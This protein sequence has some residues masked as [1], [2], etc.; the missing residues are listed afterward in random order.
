MGNQ[1][2]SCHSLTVRG[3]M[4]YNPERGTWEGNEAQL[5]DFQPNGPALIRPKGAHALPP[6]GGAGQSQESHGMQWDPQELIWRGN[7]RAVAKFPSTT[8]PALISQLNPSSEPITKNDMVFD[9]EKM[10]WVG[11][12]TVLDIFSDIET[13][14]EKNAFEVGSEFSLSPELKAAFRRRA[15]HHKASLEGWLPRPLERPD[16]HLSAIRSV[17]SVLSSSPFRCPSFVLSTK[18]SMASSPL[19][20]QLLS[21]APPTPPT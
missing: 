19:H 13:A 14:E 18:P 9:P 4:T 5:R 11:N 12:D 10:T 6:N 7:E 2:L 16:A 3:E 1:R 8:G 17:S 15:H 21:P 20:P